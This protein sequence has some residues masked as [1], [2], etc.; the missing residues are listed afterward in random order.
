M[1]ERGWAVLTPAKHI[2]LGAPTAL[3]KNMM[4]MEMWQDTPARTS[5]H[6]WGLPIDAILVELEVS[7]LC[8]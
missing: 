5:G 8:S 3:V 6:P 1:P 7:V 2:L 4:E